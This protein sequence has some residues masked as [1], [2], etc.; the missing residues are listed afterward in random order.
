MKTLMNPLLAVFVLLVTVMTACS[1]CS[2]ESTEPSTHGTDQPADPTVPQLVIDGGGMLYAYPKESTSFSFKLNGKDADKATVLGSAV[3][4]C[5]VTNV[6]YNPTNGEGTVTVKMNV[7]L[8]ET[9]TAQFTLTTSAGT[10]SIKGTYTIHAYYMSVKLNEDIVFTGEKDLEYS[11]SDIFDTNITDFTPVFSTDV[12]WLSISDKTIKTTKENNSGEDRNAV[13]NINDAGG[14]F[15]GVEVNVKQ[16]TLPPIP[17]AGCVEFAEWSFKKACLEVADT[18][19]DGEVSLDEA[20]AVKELNISNKGIKNLKGL[21]AFENIWKI[22]AQN[23]DI[24]DATVLKELHQLYWL[25]LQGNKHLKTFD[26]T[27]CTI[28]FEHCKY[29]ITDEL[30]YYVLAKQYGV[31]GGRE[32]SV[33]S[34]PYCK[35]SKHIID[36]RQS[37]DYSVQDKAIK[38]HKHTKTWTINGEEQKYALAFMGMGY[39]DVDIQD[40]SFARLINNALNIIKRDCPEFTSKWEYFDI[41]RFE[42]FN[43]NRY[44]YMKNYLNEPQVRTDY[45]NELK[46]TI[47]ELWLKSFNIS[48]DWRSPFDYFDSDNIN[49]YHLI[50]IRLNLICHPAQE[51]IERGEC[52]AIEDISKRV[53][54]KT[55]NLNLP[56]DIITYN[57]NPTIAE[58]EIESETSK[59]GYSYQIPLETL[60]NKNEGWLGML[61]QLSDYLFK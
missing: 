22:D 46:N 53:I 43:K 16:N 55:K 1:S 38:L 8:Q 25:D 6:K 20:K 18:D 48:Y 36:Q 4:G 50:I 7:D 9:K 61:S 54:Q 5:Q 30:K 19:N 2:K 27:G 15:D 21:E 28:Y 34:D 24:E 44:M 29:E 39:L 41:Y 35:Y 32:Y 31:S 3:Y 12:D 51:G 17:K 42:H 59:T 57:I 11:I 23:N 49:N 56:Y 14:H 60:L 40:N 47:E 58:L 10:K 26:L 45:L 13:I 52:Q 37:T 33:S